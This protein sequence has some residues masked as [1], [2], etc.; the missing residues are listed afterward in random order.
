MNRKIVIV[1]GMSG[2]GKS[3]AAKTLEDV[4]FFC[5][6]NLPVDLLPKL[7][8]L[9]DS[10]GG[11]IAR[12]ALIIDLRQREFFPRYSSIMKSLELAGV[13][14]DVLFLDS[15]DDVLVR[16]YSQTRRQHP[17]AP[18]GNL[19]D[20]INKE[21]K[22]LQEIRERS[23]WIIDTSDMT[24]H[25]LRDEIRKIFN[26]YRSDYLKVVVMSFGFGKGVPVESDMVLD[27]R[28]LPNPFFVEELKAK[29]GRDP[30]VANWLLGHEVTRKF[31]DKFEELLT[32]LLPL[33]IR[34]G[35][36]YFTI[37]IG[38]TGG[39]HRSVLVAEHI[40]QL[41]VRNDY[42]RVEVKHRELGT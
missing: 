23:D 2:S 4:G 37:S 18:R 13:S 1:T 19:L 35:K 3:T 31:L 36:Q 11:E 41:L 33:Y 42:T 22:E 9:A 26:S 28:F 12:L 6:D 25:Q 40:A 8:E 14:L 30:S 34:E 5:V 27:V 15:R 7:L 20:G 17:L 24:V 38:C 39:F 21:R 10:T 29:D 32:F 16:R